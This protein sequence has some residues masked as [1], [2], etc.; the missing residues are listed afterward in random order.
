MKPS[1]FLPGKVRGTPLNSLLQHLAHWA[2]ESNSMRRWLHD[3]RLKSECNYLWSFPRKAWPYWDLKPAVLYSPEG[4]F[5][6]ESGRSP[7]RGWGKNQRGMPSKKLWT[8]RLLTLF[9]VCPRQLHF[10]S[11]ILLGKKIIAIRL[12]RLF[13]SIGFLLLLAGSILLDGISFISQLSPF[14][15]VCPSTLFLGQGRW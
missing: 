13:F 5:L 2:E 6:W 8:V 10:F 9:V 11:T 4:V 14:P 12:R 15:A 3:V 7:F 1:H